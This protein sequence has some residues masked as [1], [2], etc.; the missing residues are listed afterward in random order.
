M[1]VVNKA[2]VLCVWPRILSIGKVCCHWSEAFS[3]C[4][5]QPCY[6]CM[7]KSRTPGKKMDIS[8]IHT[9][10]RAAQ[11]SSIII[12]LSLCA[13]FQLCPRF[14]LFLHTLLEHKLFHEKVNYITALFLFLKD[15]TSEVQ[16]SLAAFCCT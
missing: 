2:V 1:C 11:M 14:L 9:A 5:S 4:V 3:L 13:T 6:L 7:L 8:S 12:C 15:V 10:S 16:E